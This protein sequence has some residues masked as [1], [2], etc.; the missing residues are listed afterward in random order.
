[1][2]RRREQVIMC[3]CSNNGAIA[4]A[5]TSSPPL[6]HGAAGPA[7]AE[8]LEPDLEDTYVRLMRSGREAVAAA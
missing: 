4:R 8:E 2:S 1:M 3:G 7:G 5:T 6:R